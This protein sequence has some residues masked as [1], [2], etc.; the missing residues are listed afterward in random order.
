MIAMPDKLSRVLDDFR[1]L[2]HEEERTDRL[3]D[4]ARRY[5]EVPP[6]IAARPFPESHRVP[7]CESEAFV[8]ANEQPDHSVR[9]YFAVENPSGVSAKA[10]AAILA[11]TTSGSRPEEIAAIPPDI[12]ETVFRR[13]MSMGKGMG[14]M[15][16]VQRVQALGRQIARKR[17]ERTAAQSGV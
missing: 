1:A 8:W 6:E 16:M 12:V 5:R 9:L 2:A 10:L 3:V 13:N 7:Y 11:E 4:Y 17:D 15:A 14:L